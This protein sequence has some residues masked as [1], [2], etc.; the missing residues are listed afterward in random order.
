MSETNKEEGIE[1]RKG[2]PLYQDW[3][4]PEIHDPALSQTSTV[5]RGS[6]EISF[7]LLRC[8]EAV[9]DLSRS[10]DSLAKLDNPNTDMRLV[11]QLASPLFTLAGC[12]LDMFN[13]LESNAK[14]YTVIT[15]SQQ[16]E[17]ANRR[18]QFRVDVPT[19]KGTDLRVVRDKID[20]HIDKDSVIKPEDFWTKVNLCS[21][22]GWMGSCLEQVLYL[23]SLDVYGWTRESKHPDIWSLMSVD[24]TL[25][26]F[27]MQD[28]KPVAILNVTFVN[29]PKNGVFSEIEAF[30]AL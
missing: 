14:D 6:N 27:Y 18:E 28:G 13:H 25:V 24:G 2:I 12:V 9:R 8:L 15:S 22:L 23:L 7:K 10:M 26:D 21:F 17:I 20:S 11:K 3:D 1:K 29:S 4:E 5:W 30:V 19:G 16:K